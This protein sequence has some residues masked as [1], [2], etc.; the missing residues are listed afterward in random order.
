MQKIVVTS[1]IAQRV[2]HNAVEGSTLTFIGPWAS[3][4]DDAVLSLLRPMTVI[5][6][7]SCYYGQL[8]PLAG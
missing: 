5:G 2:L 7:K 1:A 3:Q 4:D 8:I 6:W